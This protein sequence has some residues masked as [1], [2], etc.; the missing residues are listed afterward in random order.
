MRIRFPKGRD[1]LKQVRES[2][3]DERYADGVKKSI[4]LSGVEDDSGEHP[5]RQ[6]ADLAY[7]LYGKQAAPGAD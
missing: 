7:L 3:D 4:R 2:E 6:I 1:S 5:S